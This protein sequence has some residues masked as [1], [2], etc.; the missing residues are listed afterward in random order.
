VDPGGRD[1]AAHAQP[2]TKV[3]RSG[4]VRT[5]TAASTPSW[6][7]AFKQRLQELGYTAGQNLVI[8]ARFANGQGARLSA[9]VEEMVQL[10]VDCLAVGGTL[11][12]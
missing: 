10:Q 4:Y 9:L 6:D 5:G 11:E 1:A 2:V 3:Y 7:E 8:E 12:R